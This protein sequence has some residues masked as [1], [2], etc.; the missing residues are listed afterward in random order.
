MPPLAVMAAMLASLVVAPAGQAGPSLPRPALRVD[1]GG[2][3][4]SRPVAPGL[5]GLS[6]E[7]RS[8]PYYFGSDPAGPNPLFL[9]LVRQLTPGQS[10]VIRFG[11]DTT[12]WTWWPTPRVPRP[13][14]IKF[15]LTPRWLASTRAAAEALRAR[16]ILGIN[17]ESDSPAIARTEAGELLSGLGPGVVGGFE[18]GNEPEV[19]G[20]LGWYANAQ[21]VGVPGRPGGYD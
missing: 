18:L 6:I 3:P 7:Y 4:V 17:F 11:G 20:S 12:D 5:L 2:A 19:Y 10:P 16:L 14:G 13:P 21:G 1:V 8:A 15:A 9:S